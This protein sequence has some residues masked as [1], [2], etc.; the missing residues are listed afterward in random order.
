MFTL[1]ARLWQCY[2]NILSLDYISSYKRKYLSKLWWWSVHWWLWCSPSEFQWR[3]LW[4]NQN[5]RKKEKIEEISKQKNEKSIWIIKNQ[6]FYGEVCTGSPHLEFQWGQLWQNQNQG[7][8][9]LPKKLP[10]CCRGWQGVRIFMKTN[11]SQYIEGTWNWCRRSRMTNRPV[12]TPK[13]LS[14]WLRSSWSPNL[15]TS[16][17]FD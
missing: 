15:S 13:R 10:H 17:K 5:Q 3:Q 6:Y 8:I 1:F 2:I 9:G 12:L 11:C 14:R 16:I 7:E 4:Q